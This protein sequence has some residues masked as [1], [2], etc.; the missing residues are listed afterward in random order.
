M[1]IDLSTMETHDQGKL[2]KTKKEEK[3]EMAA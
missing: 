1:D 2:L 3:T